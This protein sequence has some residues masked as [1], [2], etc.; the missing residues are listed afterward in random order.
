ML[1]L[2]DAVTGDVVIAAEVHQSAADRSDV[3]FDLRLS[4]IMRTP[5]AG[6]ANFDGIVN[7]ADAATLAQNY[8]LE[9]GALWIHGDFNADGAVSLAD[10]AILQQ[11]L[12]PI[13]AVSGSPV[14]EP[15]TVLMT[16]VG[17][18]IAASSKARRRRR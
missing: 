17:L 4:A 15:S 11:N 12:S 8:G 14:P 16:V 18:V 6:D 7:R 1:L 2:P 10:M 3:S 9:T 13:A 5:I